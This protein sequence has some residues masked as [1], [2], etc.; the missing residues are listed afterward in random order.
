MNCDWGGWLTAAIIIIII[1]I[2]ITLVITFLLLLPLALQPTV[3]L[4]LS[5]NLLIQLTVKHRR[6]NIKH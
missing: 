3:G 2:I 4:G 5:N 1:V 6:N